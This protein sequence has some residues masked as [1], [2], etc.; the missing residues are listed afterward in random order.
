MKQTRIY[1]NQ[2]LR[3]EVLSI[4]DQ[5]YTDF[6]LLNRSTQNIALQIVNSISYD[7]LTQ[8]CELGFIFEQKVMPYLRKL[9]ENQRLEKVRG[10]LIDGYIDIGN[11]R[12]HMMFM[13]YINYNE[14]IERSKKHFITEISPVNKLNADVKS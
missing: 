3:N 13:P 1:V 9:N 5:L 12:I 7:Y 8:N 6:G 4:I 10:L 14:E 11:E 2:D